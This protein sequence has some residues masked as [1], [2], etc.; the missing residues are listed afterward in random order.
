MTSVGVVSFG[1]SNCDEDVVKALKS[2][3][4]DVEARLVWYKDSLEGCDAAVLPGGFSY[5]DY[6]RAGAIAART[7]IM[8]DVRA[9]AEAGKP[10]LGICNGAQVLAEA[11]LVPGAFTDNLSAR[12]QCRSTYVRVEDADTPFTREFTEGEVVEIPIA[13]AEGRYVS[14]DADPESLA[15]F[16][17]VDEDGRTTD[18]ANPNGSE[19]HLAGVRGSSNVLAMMPHPERRRDSLLGHDE[20]LRVFESMARAADRVEAA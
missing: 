8:D 4:L 13:H 15:V 2:L 12:F 18:D 7:P 11:G 5:G 6:L 1:G 19:M 14:G 10:V 17:Y 9:M 20:G 3:D 16:R